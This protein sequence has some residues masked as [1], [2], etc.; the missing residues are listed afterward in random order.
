MKPS[1]SSVTST[2]ALKLLSS[3]ADMI[4]EQARKY[5]QEMEELPENDP[6]RE[7]Y[8]KFIRDLLEHSRKLS[9]VVTS[10]ASSS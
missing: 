10:T 3:E 5:R 2:S 4:L 1:F 6:R 9:T 7:L 8:Q